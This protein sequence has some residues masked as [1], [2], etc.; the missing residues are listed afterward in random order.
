M[1][2]IYTDG[3]CSGNPGPGGW[4]AIIIADGG[5]RVLYGGEDLTT[6]NRMEMLAAIEGL[7]ATPPSTKVT[8]HTDSTYLINT[9]TRGWKRKA[10]Q[11]LWGCLDGEVGS[12][13]VSWKWVRGHSGHP[14]N[15]EADSIAYQESQARAG[16][17]APARRSPPGGG[18]DTPGASPGSSLTHV[19]ESGRASMVDVG[20]KSATRRVA[21]AEGRVTMQPR[22]LGMVEDNAMAKGDVLAVARV[23]GIMAAKRTPELVPLCHVLPLDSVVVDLTADQSDSAV[24]IQATA[25]TTAKTGVEME[26]LTAVSTAALTVYDMCKAVDRTMRIEGIRLVSKTGGRSDRQEDARSR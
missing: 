13:R 21:V 10:N 11:D 22:T 12:R 6:N 19:D 2:D 5:K 9:M 16:R 24:H 3:A 26:A 4:S 1:I 8:V 15:E 7:R 23:A 25:S 20:G 18:E 14:L 17:T